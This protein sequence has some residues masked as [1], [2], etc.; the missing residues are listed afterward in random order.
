VL[1]IDSRAGIAGYKVNVSVLAK[2]LV[3]RLHPVEVA[4]PAAWQEIVKRPCPHSLS[5]AVGLVS[6][7]KNAIELS[8]E[9][10]QSIVDAYEGKPLGAKI[11]QE[12]RLP[13]T[14]LPAKPAKHVLPKTS[15][16]NLVRSLVELHEW[17]IEEAFQA[18][19]W[20]YQGQVPLKS[21]QQVLSATNRIK[22]KPV[23]F[24]PEQLIALRDSY[25]WVQQQP[26]FSVWSGVYEKLAS[27]KG[28]AGDESLNQY[29]IP[30]SSEGDTPA[31]RYL[32]KCNG[33]RVHMPL[34]LA[35]YLKKKVGVE[36]ELV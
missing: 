12:L 32:W 29:E 15:Q 34:S 9:L 11:R 21:Y 1:K 28:D 23:A 14:D 24:S 20:Y 8:P 4:F 13:S 7:A 6:R 16:N 31:D 35:V 26:F 2:A 19:W 3:A 17:S 25:A 10:A 27:E 22:S 18:I 36:W 33:V 30:E 5:R